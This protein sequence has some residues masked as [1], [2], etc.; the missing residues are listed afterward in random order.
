MPI[1]GDGSQTRSYCYVDDLVRGLLVLMS[2]DGLKGETVNLGNSNELTVLQTAKI[3]EQIVNGELQN[4]LEFEYL[5]LPKD[6]PTRRKPDITKARQLLD[7]E[8]QVDF[9]EGL[10]KTVEFFKK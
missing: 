4:Q 2:K 6:D 10:K 9:E 8:P 7:W 3:I 1:Y 5:P